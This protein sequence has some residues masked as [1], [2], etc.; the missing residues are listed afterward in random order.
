MVNR[1]CGPFL[2]N[3]LRKSQEQHNQLDMH[4]GQRTMPAC[5]FAPQ[6]PC[7]LPLDIWQVWSSKG[8]DACHVSQSESTFRFWFPNVAH[9]QVRHQGKPRTWPFS[10]ALSEGTDLLSFGSCSI[11]SRFQKAITFDFQVWAGS[12]GRFGCGP[13]DHWNGCLKAEGDPGYTCRRPP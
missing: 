12:I 5:P 8:A 11:S 10:A 1:K 9:T 13:L 7:E 3:P 6:S 4:R 2:A